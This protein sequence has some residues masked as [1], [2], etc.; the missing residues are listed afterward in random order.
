MPDPIGKDT[1]PVS[2]I[3]PCYDC[4]RTIHETVASVIRQT[5]QPREL[6]LVN[7]GSRDKGVTAAAL[8]SIRDR[9]G[10]VVDIRLI[11][12]T[13][14]RGP[15]SAR[16][17]GWD[18]ATQPYIAFLD[19][20]DIWHP[21]KLAL[22]YPLIEQNPHIDVIGHDFLL[23]RDVVCFS[24]VYSPEDLPS[25][26]RKGF[27]S[28][29]LLNPFVTPSFLLKKS[30]RER[31][32]SRLRYCEDHEFLLRLANAGQVYHL[33]TKLVQLGREAFAE[34]GLSSERMLMRKGEIVMYFEA[35]KYRAD[36]VVFLP[37]LI[38][39]SVIKHIILLGLSLVQRKTVSA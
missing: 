4:S 7:D 6:I 14:N 23:K 35:L 33:K 30:V 16:N 10:Y 17:A 2:V 37:L 26:I 29:L 3:I 5:K 9:W 32:N 21:Q 19:A 18:K 39:F 1:V 25:P 38:L 36:V 28:V 34:G 8:A 15:A 31:F 22:V 27:Y 20:D 24:R 13:E 11:E 12:F